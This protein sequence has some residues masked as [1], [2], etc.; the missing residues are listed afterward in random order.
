M[1]H[2]IVIK[3]TKRRKNKKKKK[4]IVGIVLVLWFSLLMG[5]QVLAEP[6]T[7]YAKPEHWLSLPTTPIKTVD[8]FYLYPTVYQKKTSTDSNGPVKKFV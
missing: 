7:D 3:V 6:A 5:G 4:K 2:S 8:V 1:L